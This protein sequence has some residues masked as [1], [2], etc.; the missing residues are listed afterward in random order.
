M[1]ARYARRGILI[2]SNLL[3]VYLLGK[4][5]PTALVWCRATKSYSLRDTLDLEALVSKFDRL[6]TTAHVL[7][8]VSNL[9]T[10][11]PENLRL[12][13]WGFFGDV[14]RARLVERALQVR[15]FSTDPIFH[16]FGVT[17][18]AIAAIEPGSVLVLTA[19]FPLFGQLSKRGVDVLNFNHLRT[20]RFFQ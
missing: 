1:I 2:D 7:T 10:S 3:V 12:N 9:T 11:L 14:I 5:D 6:L 13:F 18:T 16:R 19:D 15:D 4:F 17:D 8:E 20:A